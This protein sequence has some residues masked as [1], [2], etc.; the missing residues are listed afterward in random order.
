M[1]RSLSWAQIVLNQVNV[2]EEGA[3]MVAIAFYLDLS[4]VS[5]V[6]KES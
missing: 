2:C 1:A 4:Q 6:Q 5:L 3:G